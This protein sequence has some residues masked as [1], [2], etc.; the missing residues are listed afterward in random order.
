ME[1]LKYLKTPDKNE[2]KFYQGFPELCQ[3]VSLSMNA[4]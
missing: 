2:F 3:V 1:S 4:F